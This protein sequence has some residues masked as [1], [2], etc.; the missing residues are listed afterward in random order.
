MKLLRNAIL[1][2][3]ALLLPILASPADHPL[4]ADDVTLLLIGGG[5]ADRLVTL[6]EQRGVDF[7][8]TPELEKKFRA[9][10]ATDSVITA[11]KKAGEKTS[12]SPAR[13]SAA[14]VTS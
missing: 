10:G 8:L 9:N 14:P 6:I 13:S 4:S 3:F 12:A 7:R 2:A 1:V 11:L 5:D